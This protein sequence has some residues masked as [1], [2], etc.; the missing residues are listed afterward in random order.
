MLQVKCY[1]NEMVQSPYSWIIYLLLQTQGSYPITTKNF[2]DEER[3]K[4]QMTEIKKEKKERS[5]E[6]KKEKTE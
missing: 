6:M 2:P 4:E 1:D 5:Q 3:T